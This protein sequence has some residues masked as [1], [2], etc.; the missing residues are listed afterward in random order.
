MS[1]QCKNEWS[2]LFAAA[3]EHGC[4]EGEVRPPP[5]PLPTPPARRLISQDETEKQNYVVV[6]R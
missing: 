3:A 1:I 5:L 6:T 2:N 4:R